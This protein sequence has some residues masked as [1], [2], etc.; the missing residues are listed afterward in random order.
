MEKT[1]KISDSKLITG[2]TAD[3]MK[4]ILQQTYGNRNFYGIVYNQLSSSKVLFKNQTILYKVLSK[5]D[6]N[7]PANKILALVFCDDIL[8]LIG[9]GLF[10]EL[11]LLYDKNRKLEDFEEYISD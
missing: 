1:L 4:F 6:P 5:S 7:Y 2:I 10:L 9:K 8:Q 11:R 3:E